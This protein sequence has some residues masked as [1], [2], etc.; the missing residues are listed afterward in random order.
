M[1]ANRAFRF[2][3]IAVLLTAQTQP[4]LVRSQ[5]SSS[6]NLDG[7]TTDG[8]A[9]QRRWEE[10]FRAV[11]APA[12]AREHLRKLT[13]EPHVAGT[14]EDY[15]TAVY[16][17]DQIS[18]YGIPAELKEYDVLLPYPKQPSLL[19]LVSPRRERLAM[20]EA[21]VAEDPTSSSPKI[22]P[23]FN[24]YSATG[25][26][27]APLVY[28]N[29]GLPPDY[30]ALKKIGVDVKGKIAIARYGNSF[31][32]VKAKVAQDHG[33]VGLIIYSDPAD[34][35]YGQ[36]DVYPKGPWRP[37]T[38]AQ[39][40]SVQYLFVAPGDPL[41]PGK[42]SVPGVP[43]LKMEEADNLTRIPVQP[44]SY[45]DARRLLEPLRGPVRPK[46]FREACRSRI[47]WAEPTTCAYT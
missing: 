39:R 32:G 43:R 12:S 29:Y 26:V 9:A 25:D 40:V 15:A 13:A 16:V 14:K 18:S 20:K 23:L 8:S 45:G 1:K 7:F 17:R 44:I 31:R 30:E 35:G 11:P 19:E 6:T 4:A 41:T 3:F 37:L 2:L 33:A 42:P 36:G 27:T 21:V 34:D 22:I 24:G 28:V 46:D 5:G 47:T 38:S 10:E